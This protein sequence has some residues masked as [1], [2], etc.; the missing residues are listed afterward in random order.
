MMNSDVKIATT[1]TAAISPTMKTIVC[2][3]SDLPD[4]CGVIRRAPWCQSAVQFVPAVD[5]EQS[6][7]ASERI[8]DVTQHRL[9]DQRQ[10]QWPEPDE[11]VVE[12]LERVRV[13][14]LL[15][16][17]VTQLEDH[18]LAHRVVAVGGI[19]G[20]AFGLGR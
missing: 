1:A 8:A 3:P 13:A 15:L 9:A 6:V 12:A 11:L 17:V 20:P 4:L 19:R 7:A 14:R 16:I 2:L 10:G 18:E 5:S